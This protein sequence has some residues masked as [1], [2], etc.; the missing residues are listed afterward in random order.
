MSFVL[1]QM[2]FL[3]NFFQVTFRREDYK[4]SCYLLLQKYTIVC[5]P[6]RL[7]YIE[8]VEVSSVGDMIVLPLLLLRRTKNRKYL[9]CAKY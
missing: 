2:L 6:L 1:P 5:V 4:Q 7:R 3:K 9:E 8:F